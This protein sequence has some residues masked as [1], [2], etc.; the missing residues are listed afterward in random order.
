MVL[1]VLLFLFKFWEFGGGLKWYFFDDFF[2][3][4]YKF[5]WEFVSVF[6]RNCILCRFYLIKKIKVMIMWKMR[7]V[8]IEGFLYNLWK[9][10]I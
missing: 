1:K 8:W 3:F 4:Y 9:F 10:V 5:L 7:E 2:E 6:V